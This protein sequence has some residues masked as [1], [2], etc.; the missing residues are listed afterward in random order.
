VLS[1]KISRESHAWDTN[2][3]ACEPAYEIDP[4]FFSSEITD[5]ISFLLADLFPN[6]R[7]TIF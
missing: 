7:A 3:D 5:W 6:I 4:V 2:F 1:R